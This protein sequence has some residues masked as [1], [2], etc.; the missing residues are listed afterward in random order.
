M[1]FNSLY[2]I[3]GEI[4][5]EYST[6]STEQIENFIEDV[7]RKELGEYEAYINKMNG[8]IMEYVQLKNL[9]ESILLHLSDGIKTKMNIGGN[10]FMSAKVSD[11]SKILVNVGLNYH[12]EFTIDEAVKFCDFKVKSLENEANVIREKAIETKAHIKLALLTIG[13]KEKLLK[14][15]T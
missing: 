13:E 11:T 14:A 8:E 4:T 12:V 3:G 1:S 9:C 5:R 2:Q 10:F 15:E 7:L 6:R